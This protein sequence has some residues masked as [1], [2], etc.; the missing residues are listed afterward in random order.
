[1]QNNGFVEVTCTR[2]YLQIGVICM[3]HHYSL[4]ALGLH[5]RR[6]IAMDLHRER[7]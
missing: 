1:M 2:R 4:R 5:Y 7:N 3:Y 6:Y